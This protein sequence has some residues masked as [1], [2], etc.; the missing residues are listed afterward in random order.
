MRGNNSDLI[1]KILDAREGS[2]VEV[3]SATTIFNFKWAPLSK[4]IN[5]E[6]LSNHG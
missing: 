1:K 5:F 2:W 6:Y 3:S 4:S